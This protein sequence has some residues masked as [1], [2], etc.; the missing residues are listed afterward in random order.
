[1]KNVQDENRS[2]QTKG[3]SMTDT[4]NDTDTVPNVF[5]T[6]QMGDDMSMIKSHVDRLF[7]DAASRRGHVC[8][9]PVTGGH[10]LHGDDPIAPQKRTAARALLAREYFAIYGPHDAPP[11]PLSDAELEDL[12]YTDPFSHIVEGFAYSL[13]AHDWDFNSHP[14][15]EDFACG[16]MAS[17][18]APDFVKNDEALRKRY[19]PRTL[20]GLGPGLCWEPPKQ[21]ARTMASY[22]RSMARCK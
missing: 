12:K 20:H 2:D 19:P 16:C 18:H 17:E 10:W 8:E 6:P 5:S 14:S 13:R 11:L 15:F 3:A 7:K 4:T 9:N 1:M 22:Q 21:H